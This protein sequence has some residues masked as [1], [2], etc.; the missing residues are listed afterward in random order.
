MTTLS[1]VSAINDPLLGDKR[2]WGL[3][4]RMFQDFPRFL[5]EAGRD[6]LKRALRLCIRRLKAGEMSEKLTARWWKWR[7]SLSIC[8]QLWVNHERA[9][10]YASK[11]Q[12]TLGLAWVK[13]VSQFGIMTY[14]APRILFATNVWA[15]LVGRLAELAGYGQYDPKASNVIWPACW[16]V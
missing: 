13:G 1:R 7:D 5:V 10:K 15:S 4:K 14:D 11:Q 16:Q 3:Y 6:D 2:V 12:V 9:V 8:W